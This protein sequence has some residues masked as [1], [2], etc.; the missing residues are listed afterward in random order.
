MQPST[1]SKKTYQVI[2][3]KDENGMIFARCDELHANAEGK[4]EAEAKNNIKEA[5]ELMVDHLNKDKSFSLKFV[6]KY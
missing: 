2:L 5:I 3:D 1:V 4:T 6:H